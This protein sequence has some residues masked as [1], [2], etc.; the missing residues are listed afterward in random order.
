MAK[1]FFRSFVY[2]AEGI[3]STFK[4]GFNIKVQLVFAILAIVLAIV[5]GVSPAE[6]AI[7]FLCIGL[8]IGGECM[9]TAIEAVVDLSSP[10]EHHLAK[11]AKD[12]AAGA[13]LIA[14]IASV[15]VAIAVFLPRILA[16][17]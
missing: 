14:S 3:A 10:D 4:V 7:I 9:N 11:R 1:G 15:A 6:W 5:F 16:L 13:V 8:V 17:L 12:C 2:A